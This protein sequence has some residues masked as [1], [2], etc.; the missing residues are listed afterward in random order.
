MFNLSKIFKKPSEE[1]RQNEVFRDALKNKYSSFQQV[2]SKNNQVLEL[3]ADMEE[4]LSGEYLFDRH[5]IN[6]NCMLIADGVLNIIENLNTLSKDKYTILY[7][8]HND[9]VKEIKKILEYKI[10]IPVSELSI[11][12]ENIT[13][14][15]AGIVGGKSA[16]LAEVKGHVNLPVPEGFAISSY[17]F[18]R[19]ME[20]NTLFEKINNVLSSLGIEKLEELNRVSKEIYDMVQKAD[21]PSDLEKAVRDGYS[22]LYQKINK[23][24]TVSVRSSA[25]REDGEFSFAG[26][27][28]TYLN[29]PGDLILQKYKE[30]VASLFNPRAIFYYKTKGFSEA[31]MIMAVCVLSMVDAEAGG[32]MYTTDP[33]DPSVDHIIINAIYGLGKWLVDGTITPDLYIVSRHPEGVIINKRISEQEKMLICGKPGEL[34]EAE[35][36]EEKKGKQCTSDD[37][38]RLLARYALDLENY[39]GGPQDIEWSIGSD[40]K[41]YILQTRPLKTIKESLTVCIPT[42]MQGYNVLID[43]GVIACRGI[44]YGKAFIL[45]DEGDLKDFPEGAVLV[46][47]HT[48]PKYVTVMNKASAII[49]DVGSATGHMASLS[50]EY[51]VPTILDTEVATRV[52]RDGQGITVDAINCNIYEGKVEELLEY[53]LK[54]KESFKET[55]LFKTLGKALKK[56]VPLNLIDP[57]GENFKPEYCK[58]FHDITRFAH[59]IAMQEM[60]SIGKD[61]D[62]KGTKAIPLVAG[63]PVDALLLDIGDGIKGLPGKASTEDILSMPLSALLKGMK[64]MNWPEPRPVDAKGFLGMLAH[65]AS[66][67]EE[68]LYEMGKKSFCIVSRNYM[69]FSIRLGYH[70]SM[71][72]AYAGDNVND[73]YIKFFFKGGG[74]A[75]DRRLRRVRLIT[76]I[77]KKM[78]FGV[79][80][81]ED[82][83]NAGL[84]KYKKATIEDKLD[85][86]G[87]LSA[88]TKQLDMV[89]FND[90]ITDMYIEDFI[91]KYIP[92]S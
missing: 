62:I 81:K 88:Y 43:K 64:S 49:T 5:Y 3:M 82:V 68:Q 67:P 31:E 57:E 73:N 36:P 29:V 40:N 85:I 45:K 42:R 15:M 14:E 76:E 52:L 46:V 92:P 26:Q 6:A 17:A 75:L 63:V 79:N 65:S 69:N 37:H 11:P 21:I 86:L 7:K 87:K 60:F 58:T 23:E 77:L 16:H 48:N 47:K 34:E 61:H 54:K 59:E 22:K 80:V 44:G 25:I 38:I 70:F 9:I 55:H 32:V 13:D 51:Q 72:E 71:I 30:V 10:E 78:G 27:Y 35:V 2:L 91:K 20:H 66:V 53:A 33:N 41:V 1:V 19:F 8:V 89:M 56:I 50:R 39:Y 24:I 90:A 4:K 12:F 84:T 18:K 74:A 83:I 28:A